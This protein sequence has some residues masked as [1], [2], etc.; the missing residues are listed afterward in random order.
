[1]GPQTVLI[2][3]DEVSL[4]ES[5]R[6][7]LEQNQFRVLVAG[8]GPECLERARREVP[9]LILLDVMLPGLDGFEVCRT[10]RSRGFVGSILL[11]TARDDEIDRVLGLELGADDYVTKPF[12]HRELLARVRAH[13][14]RSQRL[15]AQDQKLQSGELELW[16]ERREACYRGQKLELTPR[17]FQLLHFLVENRRRAQSRDRILAAVWGYDY[18]G[19]TRVVNVT[20]QR[21]R[22]KLE[23]DPAHP[24]QIVTVRGLGYMFDV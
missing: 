14:R 23:E 15:E 10:L 21:L 4:V 16:P 22:D 2:V 18:A 8:S 9:D 3:D 12:R 20:I 7:L 17:E 5:V 6:Y 1:M 24:T 19:E 11:L 13:L